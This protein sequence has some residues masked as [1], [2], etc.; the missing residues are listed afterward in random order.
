MVHLDEK[1][2]KTGIEKAVLVGVWNRKNPEEKVRDYLDELTLL[3]ET[4]GAQTMKIFM[5]KVEKLNSATLLGSGK[6]E[7]IKAYVDEEKID[8]VVFDE[9]LSPSQVRNIDKILNVKVLDR[10]GIILHIFSER[11]RTAQAR[12]QVDLAQLQYMLPRLTGLW[13]HLSK[14]KGGIGLKGAGEK[15]IETDR[16]IIRDKISLLK[17]QLEK[18]DKQNATRRK[19]RAEMIRV[20]LVGYT[21]AG[22][23]T[24]MNTLAKSDV[25]AEDKLFAT[26]DT[27]VRKLVWENI[28]FL[29][30]DTV[31]FIRKLPHG[32]IECFKST[33]DEARE[34]DIL[35]HVVDLSHPGFQDQIRTVNET[36]SELG[37]NQKSTLVVFNKIDRLSPEELAEMKESY[38]KKENMPA[39]F[40]SAANRLNLE[41]LREH[42]L[43]EVKQMYSVRYPFAAHQGWSQYKE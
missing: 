21:N 11:A 38:M 15:E 33:L 40:V 2:D 24:L 16:R 37:A 28:P 19:D 3:T 17:K 27:T 7:E 12:A 1:L 14:Q 42:L 5:Q 25:F 35:L 31:G 26:L 30:S 39:V 43:E 9:D 34:S 4:A 10:S 6:L 13:T 22:K 20:S 41:E 18:I 8:L 36:L 29:I 23:S 32:L